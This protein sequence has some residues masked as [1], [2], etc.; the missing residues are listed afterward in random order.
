MGLKMCSA[1]RSESSLLVKTVVMC[2]QTSVASHR[3][4][5]LS[6]WREVFRE[7]CLIRQSIPTIPPPPLTVTVKCVGL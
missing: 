6:E 5:F 2:A 3:D 4:A 1:T 7:A